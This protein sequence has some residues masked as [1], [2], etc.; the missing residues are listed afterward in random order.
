M[1]SGGT[2][3]PAYRND[4]GYQ[5]LMRELLQPGQQIEGPAILPDPYSTT[6]LEEGWSCM[7]N[8]QGTLVLTDDKK[9]AASQEEEL[10]P[11]A[12]LELFSRRFMS[13]AENMGAML[14]H[15]S[16]SVNVKERLDFSC[17]LVDAE[18]YLVANAP[19]IPVHL[20]S[21]GICVRSLLCEFDLQPGDTMVT[22][23]PAYGGSH[24]PDIT[25]V[26]P[27]YR[28]K[29]KESDLLSTGPTMRRSAG[30]VPDPCPRRQVP[31]RRGC[32]HQSIL[33]G[34]KGRG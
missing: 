9:A 6:F 21:L 28:S 10:A 18:G 5:V 2:S 26:S 1:S 32:G 30:S 13:I 7:V 20:G 31:G 11:E 25:L 4:Q 3:R 15:T 22:N 27:V 14:Q 16:V 8:Q 29:A 33:P 23:H 34:E 12:E 24:L 17:A 19:H